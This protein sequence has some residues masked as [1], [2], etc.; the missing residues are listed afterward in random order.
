MLL[1]WETQEQPLLRTLKRCPEETPYQ[2]K[3]VITPRTRE[4]SHHEI[5]SGDSHLTTAASSTWLPPRYTGL[6][7]CPRAPCPRLLFSLGHRV[8]NPVSMPVVVQQLKHEA[9]TLASTSVQEA[10]KVSCQLLPPPPPP[11]L[12]L[13]TSSMFAVS[14]GT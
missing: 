12:L 1:C 5:L 13:P 6:T 9:N 7:C 8:L 11:R 2:A 10:G 3:G 4:Q 14:P